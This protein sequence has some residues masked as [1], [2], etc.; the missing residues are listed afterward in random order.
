MCVRRV[1]YDLVMVALLETLP[2]ID[3]LRYVLCV[4]AFPRP[5]RLMVVTDISPSSSLLETV[6]P[7]ALQMIW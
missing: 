1:L 7:R 3:E 6:L 2:T 4:M 5:V